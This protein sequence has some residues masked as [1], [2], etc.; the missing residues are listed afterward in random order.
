M[1]QTWKKLMPPGESETK[2]LSHVYSNSHTPIFIVLGQSTLASRTRTTTDSFSSTRF[3]MPNVYVE[4]A[5]HQPQVCIGC[6]VA[7]QEIIVTDVS[8]A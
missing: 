3:H 2:K 4:K 8:A 7:H 5:D 1:R 6:S